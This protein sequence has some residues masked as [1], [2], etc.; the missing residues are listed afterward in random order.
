[1]CSLFPVANNLKL[2]FGNGKKSFNTFFFSYPYK[3]TLELTEI[4][5]IETF[6]VL[7]FFQMATTEEWLNKLQC[8]DV[9]E[10][11]ELRIKIFSKVLNW[12][13]LIM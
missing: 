5:C 10:N 6:Y 9:T 3:S 12:E 11:I 7:I 4:I 2:S 13:M 1:M 8:N